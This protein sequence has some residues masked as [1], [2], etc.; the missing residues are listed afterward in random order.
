M[1][2]ITTTN[3]GKY[4]SLADDPQYFG[5]YLNMARLNIFNISNHVAAKFGL[6]I[7]AEEGHI[8]N[9]FLC[10]PDIKKLNW[11]H[12]Y[13]QT[14]RF[15]PLLRIFDSEALPKEEQK[16]I[17][18]VGKDFILMSNTLRLVFSEVQEFRNDY[19]HYWSTEKGKTRKTH[20][21]EAFAL[22]LKINF[23]RGIAYTK[24]RFK[25]VLEE[26]DFDL[27][28][29]K[30]V[31][32]PDGSITTVGL[33][34]I[35]CMF[36]EREYAFQFIGKI[37]GLKG[38]QNNSFIATREVLMTFCVKLPHDKLMSDDRKQAFILDLINELNRCPQELYEVIGEKDQQQFLP[39]QEDLQK[40]G[41]TEIESYDEYLDNLSKQIRYRN[42]YT[43]FA[44]R[45]IDERR[46]F[47]R[48]NFQ[49]GLGKFS[50]GSYEKFFNGDKEDRAITE[51]ARAFGHLTDYSDEQQVAAKVDKDGRSKGFNPFS[52]SFLSGN[53]KIG[54]LQ[55]KENSIVIDAPERKIGL[56]LRQPLPEA[57]LSVHELPK[58]ILLDYL[59]PG[60]PERLI[61]DFIK[62]NNRLLT[63]D[64]IKE[65]QSKIPESFDKFSHRMDSRGKETYSEGALK[66]LADRKKILNQVLNSY[67][68]NDKQIPGRILDYWLN[69]KDIDR[70]RLFGERIKNMKR[71]CQS[72]LNAILKLRDKGTGRIPKTGEMASFLAKD[73][74]DT[75]TSE[76]KKHKITSFYYD[77]IQE[78]LALY[79]DPAKKQLF[80]N[81]V[82][83]ELELDKNGGHPFLFH[84]DMKSIN[85]TSELYE[86]YL[87]EKAGKKIPAGRTKAGETKLKDASWIVNTFYK[88]KI[89]ERDGKP[90]TVVEMPS[91]PDQVPFNLRQLYEKNQHPLEQWLHH[92]KKGVGDSDR[93]KPVDLPTNLFDEMLEMQ[94]RSQLKDKGIEVS[95]QLKWNRLFTTWWQMRDDDVQRF[96]NSERNYKIYEEDV[97]FVPDSK[98]KFSEYYAHALEA[99]YM[100]KRSERQKE[101]RNN[102]RLPEILYSQVEKVFKQVIAGTEKE[103]RMIQ[104]QDR[105]SLLMLEMLLG[106]PIKLREIGEWL[107]KT[108]PIEQTVTGKLP[109]NDVGE[110]LKKGEEKSI[111]RIITADRK[112]KDYTVL[113]KFIFDRRLPGLFE[114]LPDHKIC[115]EMLKEELDRYNKARQEIFDAIFELEKRICSKDAEGVR[116]LFVD[117]DGILKE[118]NIQHWPYLLWLKKQG[119]IDERV[120]RFMNMIRNSFSHN[121]FPHKA[122]IELLIPEWGKKHFAETI[123]TVY[124]QKIQE[125]MAKL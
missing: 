78:C 47:A 53:N 91:N 31:V 93:K 102:S 28:A 100:K 68:L 106:T 12:V 64:F 77:K 80:I 26:Q 95:E 71:D 51:N 104:E 33:V 103:I 24:E 114:Y 112:G 97:C 23:K 35:I 4:R 29:S 32:N 3:E 61:S 2:P 87:W 84:I 92:L 108:I 50:L 40:F 30:E 85:Y 62:K 115:L 27:V 120:V 34:F 1:G 111:T 42:R 90:I 58:I 113:R 117:D 69:I 66:H 74:I 10:D 60:E 9:S 54:L 81:I 125:I 98:P 118:G 38:T 21:S 57:F 122:T 123:S 73:I 8:K 11:P 22:F 110:T 96:Y 20:V 101:K 121:Q 45:Y 43:E 5:G 55:K 82:T 75:L 25:N 89:G 79:A 119:Y 59:K 48:Y 39:R 7:L 41:D 94:L 18:Q 107:N 46:M 63:M 17:A 67:G 105:T 19:S 13:S 6:R 86:Q 116:L 83:N 49:I 88:R 56:K 72:R 36:L 109:F 65:I 44:L 52:P 37:P 76:E 70:D 14:K 15:L 99:A 124:N 16:G